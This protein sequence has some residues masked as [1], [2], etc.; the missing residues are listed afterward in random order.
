MVKLLRESAPAKI[1]LFLRVTGRRGNGYHEL[2]SVFL[3]V[4]IHDR[5]DIEL[6]PAPSASVHLRCDSDAIPTNEGN[7]AFRAAREFLTEFSIQAEVRIDLHKEIPA[8]AGLGGG[9]SDAGAVLRMMATLCGVNLSAA[10]LTAV[11]MRLGADV[12]FFLDPAPSRVRGIGERSEALG[13]IQKPFLLIVVPPFEVSTALVFRDLRPE[14]WSGP[15]PDRDILAIVQGRIEREHLVNDLE[16]VA[17]AKW[18]EI[19]EVKRMLEG[20]GARAAA[21]SGSGGSVF[22]IFNS[23]GEASRAGCEIARRAPQVRTFTASV[24]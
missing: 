23:S 15:A 13:R 10:S 21:M 7:L 19:E 4:S 17:I 1:N 14:H 22:G 11:A 2:D 9:S 20:A 24:L 12:A 16:Q 8:G 3:P 18:P 5:L 6:R